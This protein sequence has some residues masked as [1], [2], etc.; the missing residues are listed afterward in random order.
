VRLIRVDADSRELQNHDVELPWERRIGVAEDFESQDST[1]MAIVRGDGAVFGMNLATQQFVETPVHPGLPNRVPPAAW[2]TSPDGRRVYLGYNRDY[3]WVD[4]RFYLDYGRPPNS[5]PPAALAGE[6]SV[7]DTNTWAKVGTI[8]LKMLFWNAVVSSDG[9][10]LYAT[11]PQK[12]SV[13]V[14]DTA[15]RHQTGV[16]K[17][18]GAPALVL[19][20]P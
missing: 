14:I 20:A 16:L 6:F 12:H 17:V 13:L 9:N 7:Y 5:R 10:S 2:P 3:Y 1:A 15:R 8:R 4:N 19:V 18:G 11:V